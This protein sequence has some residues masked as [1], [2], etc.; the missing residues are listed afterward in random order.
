M[1]CGNNMTG[2]Q[3]HQSAGRGTQAQRPIEPS[4]PWQMSYLQRA[5]RAIDDDAGRHTILV[6]VWVIKAGHEHAIHHCSSD[7]LS[8]HSSGA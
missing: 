3:P 7:E 8:H 6:V 4:R 1:M 2:I 5:D